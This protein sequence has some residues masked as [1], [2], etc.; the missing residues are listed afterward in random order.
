M[1][2]LPSDFDEQDYY[3][4]A[5]IMNAKKKEDRPLSTMAFLR[6]MGMNPDE[7]TEEQQGKEV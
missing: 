1:H 4:M 6:S 3:R 2:V 7:I 5:E